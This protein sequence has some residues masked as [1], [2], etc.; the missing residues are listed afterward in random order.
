M[1]SIRHGRTPKQAR[2]RERVERVLA[3]TANELAE[4]GYAQTTT[5]GIAARAGVHVPSVYQYFANKDALV[6]E[7]WD[8]HV[9][10][11]ITLL[12]AMLA[13]PA[14]API[15]DTARRYVS[16]VIEMHVAQPDLLAELYA[17][18]PKLDGVRNLREEA[19]AALM[20]YLAHHRESL[21]PT[22]LEMAAFVLASAVEGV[23]RQF[24]LS[25]NLAV[26]TLIDEVTELVTS[27]L[28]VA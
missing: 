28:G 6:A 25:P 22:Q 20:P 16:A 15:E 9:D 4:R 8:R 7:L 10:R 18:A 3:G 17:Q 14:S 19:I 2:A 27:E 13:D 21:R 24:A 23:A 1:D 12:R 11:V 26:V 5:N